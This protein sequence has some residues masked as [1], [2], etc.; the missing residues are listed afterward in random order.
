MR[1]DV[2]ELHFGLYIDLDSSDS[3]ETDFESIQKL[4]KLIAGK[5]EL[6]QVKLN[7][8]F[9]YQQRP[10]MDVCNR[11]L[12]RWKGIKQ[13]LELIRVKKGIEVMELTCKF[14]HDNTLLWEE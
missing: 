7:F 3:W 8:T 13:E 4:K 14:R 2:K 9:D 10:S 12:A 5:Y 1:I 6:K 11:A